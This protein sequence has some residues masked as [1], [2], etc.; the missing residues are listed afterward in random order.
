MKRFCSIVSLFLALWLMLSSLA[1]CQTPKED[2]PAGDD[3]PVD[4]PPVD[5]PPVD[6][7][8]ADEPGTSTPDDP[9]PPEDDPDDG[10]NGEKDDW[11]RTDHQDKITDF[12]TLHGRTYMKEQILQLFWT[13][14]GFSLRFDGTGVQADLTTSTVNPSFYGFLNIYVDGALAPANTVC[15]TQNGTYTLIEGLDAGVHTIEVRKRNEA[16]YG[17]SATIGVRTLNITDGQFITQAPKEPKLQIE[18]IGDSITCGFGNMVTDGSGA[19]FTTPTED[20]TMTYAALTGRALGADVHVLSRSGICYVTGANRDSIYDHYGHT[21]SLPGHENCT[22]AWDFKAEPS[23]VVVIN[24]GT[25]DSGASIDGKPITSEQMTAKAIEFIHMVREHN[26]TA[27][28]VWAYGMMDQGRKG[29]LIEAVEAVNAEGDERVHFVLLPLQNTVQNGVGV[30][31]HPTIQSH[32]LAAEVLVG[33]LEVLLEVPTDGRALLEAQIRCIKEYRL[34]DAGEYESSSYAAYQAKLA[35][36]E[37]MLD[38][39]PESLQTY[40]QWINDLC[41][42]LQAIV[43]VGE[44]SDEYI[45]IDTCDDRDG[46]HLNGQS[47][48]VD[49]ENH[50]WGKG[51]FTTT[52][53]GDLSVNFIRDSSPYGIHLPH[54]WADW[55]L[56]AWI[57]LD[58]PADLPGGSDFELSQQVDRIEIAYGLNS[59]GLKQG[60][61]HVVIPISA[62]G[63]PGMNEFQT[64]NHVRI[65]W[66][67]LS[68]TITFKVDDIT[69][70]RGRYAKDRSQLEAYMKEAK[71]R[72]LHDEGNHEQLLQALELA[73]RA[74]TQRSVDL[75]AERLRRLLEQ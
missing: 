31:G 59:L 41:E 23:D 10:E 43:P 56:E 15:V 68:E 22:D 61:N 60:W 38:Q 54:D 28:I 9:P 11:I 47:A 4:E 74:T 72:L 58:Y 33:A 20:G 71:E 37:R 26:P 18:F 70:T 27:I 44:V 32:I 75:A 53:T 5:E 36:A 49:T 3:P 52:G 55:Y 66:R 24:L 16:V 50:L 13:Y 48:G 12:L 34:K 69:L 25:N 29:A 40:R 6:E 17:E 67:F 73:E 57:Y 30:H 35:A 7:P 14:S 19:L 45:V 39:S 8:P 64:L 1:G 42:G 63:K 21:A 2:P 62:A 51:C 65:F 46:W